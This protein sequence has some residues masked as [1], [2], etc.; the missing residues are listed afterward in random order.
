MLKTHGPAV[1]QALASIVSLIRQR[2]LH[3]GDRLPPIREM[4][5][6]FHL[7]STSVWK[8]LSTAKARGLVSTV[9]GGRIT[10]GRPPETAVADLAPI[11]E[12]LVWQ[13]KRTVLEH[14]I[15]TGVFLESGMLPTAKELRA[16]Y[17]ICAVT[18]RKILGS[19]AQAGVIVQKGKSFHVAEGFSR[20]HRNTVALLAAGSGS[21]ISLQNQRFQRILETLEVQC[22]KLGLGI[23]YIGLNRE[24]HK[25]SRKIPEV[26]ARN[27]TLIGYIMI[28]PWSVMR[29]DRDVTPSLL[30]QIATHRKPMALYDSVGSFE[31]S[32]PVNHSGN[33]QVFQIA[34]RSAGRDVARFLRGLGHR[35]FAYVS[36]V[37]QNDWSKNRLAGLTDVF[38]ESG[39]SESIEPV[40]VDNVELHDPRFS[41]LGS[42]PAGESERIGAIGSP[43]EQLDFVIRFLEQGRWPHQWKRAHIAFMRREQQL[44]RAL[45]KTGG[46]DTLFADVRDALLHNIAHQRNETLFA[47]LFD[48]ALGHQG[49]TAWVAAND[50]LAA[51]AIRFLKRKG[52]RV[53]QDISV[54]GFDNVPESFEPGL[55][56][57]DFCLSSIVH[58][59][60]W[61]VLHPTKRGEHFRRGPIESSGMII[62][63]ASTGPVGQGHGD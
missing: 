35:R 1:Q 4:A 62:E 63:R 47:D 59:M 40:T 56:T 51:Q 31:T 58:Q 21:A 26:L 15:S 30:A 39:I 42:L 2:N 55:T 24:D 34:G 46:N 13:K 5:E 33:V 3:P 49:C 8:A 11:T 53:P 23:E 41:W 36:H 22:G 18:L 12:N 43:L 52:V 20:P 61:F 37:H 14:D 44:L 38:R 6:A 32:T 45:A 25:N 10:A 17:A 57:Y 48:R 29:E 50:G 9:R 16:R 54:I 7:S 19:L 60:L 28:D 27:Q